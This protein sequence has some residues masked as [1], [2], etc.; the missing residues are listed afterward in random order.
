MPGVRSN[1]KGQKVTTFLFND[2]AAL[3]GRLT[4]HHADGERAILEVEDIE[5]IAG[6]LAHSVEILEELDTARALNI[7]IAQTILHNRPDRAENWAKGLVVI[8]KC[9]LADDNPTVN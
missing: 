9:E 6:F 1:N 4:Q 2:L 5:L 8:L 7:A 3:L